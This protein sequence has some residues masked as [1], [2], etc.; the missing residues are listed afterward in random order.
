MVLYILPSVAIALLGL[1]CSSNCIN[2][3]HI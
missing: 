2:L 1:L 3:V